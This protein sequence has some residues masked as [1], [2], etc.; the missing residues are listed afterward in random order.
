MKKFADMY[1]GTLLVVFVAFFLVI[2]AMF[3]SQHGFAEESVTGDVYQPSSLIFPDLPDSHWAKGDIELLY[4]VQ[5]FKEKEG[6]SFRPED[7]V[8][9]AEFIQMIM[10]AKGIPPLLAIGKQTFV[11]VPADT[12][13]YPYVEAAYSIGITHGDH[14]GQKNTFRPNDPITRE[15]LMVMAIRA[16]G[17]FWQAES[18][19]WQEVS[20][21]LARFKDQRD[22]SDWARDDMAYAARVGMTLGYAEP[23]GTFTLRPQRLTTRAEA[24]VYANRGVYQLRKDNQQHLVVNGFPVYYRELKTMEA[25]AYTAGETGVGHWTATGWYVRKGIVAVD[26]RIIPYGTHM[27]IE[28]Y[29]FAVAADRGSAIKNNKIDLYVP[30]LQEAYQFGRQ[31]NVKVYI[32]D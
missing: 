24:A 30:T 31:Y 5:A 4:Q 27:Y 1:I 21:E 9:R 16:R 7:P 18:I 6:E 12:W 17:N 2:M 19:P 25:T 23:D 8:T 29:G 28:G 20:R 26:P 11:D 14:P 13:Y 22:I 32:L 10:G 3:S 15:E